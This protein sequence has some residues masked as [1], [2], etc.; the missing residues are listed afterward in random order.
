M[1]IQLQW[2][3][4]PADEVD[5]ELVKEAVEELRSGK[6]EWASDEEVAKMFPRWASKKRL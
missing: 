4:V 6:A 2:D 1:I 3:D 5:Y